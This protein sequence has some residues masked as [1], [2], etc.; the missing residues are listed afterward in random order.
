MELD[1]FIYSASHDIR[2]PIATT[3]GIINLMRLDLHDDISKKYIGMMDASLAKLE[4][5]VREL[6][7]FGKNS[8]KIIEDESINLEQTLSEVMSEFQQ[9]HSNFAKVDV[10]SKVRTSGVFYSDPGRLQLILHNTIK[11]ALD[12]CD[13]K[14]SS[15]VVSIEMQSDADKAMIEIFDNGIGI[16]PTYVDN[17]FDIFFRGTDLSKGPGIGLYTA[18]EAATKLGGIISLNSEYGVGTSVKIEVPNSRKGKL[19]SKRNLLKRNKS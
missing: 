19:I 6:T 10:S 7:G 18:R 2:S 12:Y 11:N 1:H 9:H 17:V 13:L 4:R 14:K 3:M 8:K 5:F 16:A 15:R